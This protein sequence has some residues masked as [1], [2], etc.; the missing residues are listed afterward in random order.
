MHYLGDVENIYVANIFRT[1]STKC[2]QNRPGFVDDVTKH[3][4]CFGFAVPTAVHLQNTMLSFTNGQTRMQYV[5]STVFEQWPRHKIAL[6]PSTTCVRPAR[7]LVRWSWGGQ[8]GPRQSLGRQI[9]RCAEH[10]NVDVFVMHH[11]SSCIIKM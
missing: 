11:N 1:L 3:L 5:S 6:S 4:V 8:G 2:Y 7:V 10:P 9:R